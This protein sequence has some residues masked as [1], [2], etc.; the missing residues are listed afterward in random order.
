MK[1]K[2][3]LARRT[4]TVAQAGEV[5]FALHSLGWRDFQNLC[6]TVVGEVWGQP[7]EE[8]ASTDESEEPAEP[9]RSVF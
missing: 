4:A 1:L 2:R 6:V 5:D 8:I 9:E 7:D 3:P